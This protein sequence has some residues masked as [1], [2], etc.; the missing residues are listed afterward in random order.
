MGF[1][2]ERIASFGYAFEGVFE[3]IQSQANFKIHFLAAFLAIFAGFYFSIS[4]IEWCLIIGSIVAVWSAETFN[5]AIEHLTNLV[6]PEYHILAKKT[7]DAAAGAVLFVAIGAAL[8]G[9][10]IFL[11]KVLAIFDNY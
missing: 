4:N 3:V 10:L 9:V 7:K 1:I 6:S 5:T 2:K 11:P 8:I